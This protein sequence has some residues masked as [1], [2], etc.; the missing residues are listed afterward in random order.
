MYSL[1]ISQIIRRKDNYYLYRLLC[2]LIRLNVVPTDVD[3]SS[4][5]PPLHGTVFITAGHRRDQT[6]AYCGYG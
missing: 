2:D 3:L 6:G 1:N 5:I 4:N